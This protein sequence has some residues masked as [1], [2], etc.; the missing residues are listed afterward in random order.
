MIKGGFNA[1]RTF[2]CIT[3]SAPSQNT[4]SVGL[5]KQSGIRRSIEYTDSETHEMAFLL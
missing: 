5:E 4:R 2:S 3:T 1:I